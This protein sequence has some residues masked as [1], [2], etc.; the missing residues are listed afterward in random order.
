MNFLIDTHILLWLI[1]GD[2]RIRQETKDQLENARN[3]VFI[4][5]ASLWEI[6]IKASI[7]KL[8]LKGSLRDLNDFLVSKRIEVLQFDFDDLDTLLNLHYYHQDPFDR[9]IIAQAKTKNLAL[10]T[11]DEIIEK[12]FTN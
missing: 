2:R 6:T 10:I 8:E 9:M 11:Y 7:G 1:T 4:S 3:R 5:N 12:Y